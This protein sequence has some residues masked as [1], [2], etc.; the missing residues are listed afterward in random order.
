[1]CPM[2]SNVKY[3]GV[4]FINNA[5]PQEINRYVRGCL[6]RQESLFEVIKIRTINVTVLEDEPTTVD[7]NMPLYL[8]R[9][10]LMLP[11]IISIPGTAGTLKEGLWTMLE[12]LWPVESRKLGLLIICPILFAHDSPTGMRRPPTK[13]KAISPMWRKPADGIPTD[14]QAGVEVDYLPGKEAK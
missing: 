5:S 7:Q 4:R 2:R 10:V 9:R 12:R 8:G 13:S 3:G 11:T 14:H 6:Q 1:M